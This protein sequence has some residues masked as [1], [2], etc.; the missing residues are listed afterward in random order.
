MSQ[1]DNQKYDM[2]K[3]RVANES[4]DM[5]KEFFDKES[6]DKNSK[7]SN[8]DNLNDKSQQNNSNHSK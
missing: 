8:F 4:F 5:A 3:C 7:E 6:S 2:S 1:E